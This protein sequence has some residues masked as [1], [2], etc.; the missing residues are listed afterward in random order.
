MALVF[1]MIAN[2]GKIGLV[3]AAP[4]LRHPITLTAKEPT[5]AEVLRELEAVLEGK[6]RRDGDLYVLGPPEGLEEIA[7]LH[8]LRARDYVGRQWR[9]LGGKLRGEEWKR[10]RTRQPVEFSDLRPELQAPALQIARYLYWHDRQLGTAGVVRLAMIEKRQLRL[11]LAEDRER[12][13][14]AVLSIGVY[15]RP[16]AEPLRF[17]RHPLP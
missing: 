12:P 11:Y 14:R 17:E 13:G 4:E 1:S 15:P 6:W 7:A 9:L 2:Q 5:V 3:A 8:P 10:L 16:G